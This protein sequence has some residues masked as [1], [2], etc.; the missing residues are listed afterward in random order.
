MSLKNNKTGFFSNL[1][2]LFNIMAIIRSTLV[3]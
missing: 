3:Y 1:I 2:L